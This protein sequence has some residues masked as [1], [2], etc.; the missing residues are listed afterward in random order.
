MQGQLDPDKQILI[1]VLCPHEPHISVQELGS[2]HGLHIP[3]GGQ[4]EIVVDWIVEEGCVVIIVVLGGGSVG[5]G[6]RVFV[7]GHVPTVGSQAMPQ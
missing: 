7:E 3:P 2:L 5:H 6:V 1:L 4:Q